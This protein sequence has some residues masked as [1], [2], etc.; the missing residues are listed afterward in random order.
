MRWYGGMVISVLLMTAGN[1]QEMPDAAGSGDVRAPQQDQVSACDTVI[2]RAGNRIPARVT[3]IL[4]DTVEYKKASNPNGPLYVVGKEQVA[5]VVYA[6]GER[7]TFPVGFPIVKKSATD[8][9]ERFS[10]SLEM[11]FGV[12]GLFNV[13]NVFTKALFSFGGTPSSMVRF[14]RNF[15]AEP[16]VCCSGARRIPTTRSGSS[17]IPISVPKSSSRSGLN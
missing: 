14:H 6:N 12:F 2:D 11:N 16:S 7:D 3:R 13:D 4:P 9:I 15:A 10:A 17:S 8:P 1:A 5:M